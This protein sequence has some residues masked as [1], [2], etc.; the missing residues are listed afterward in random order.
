MTTASA[1]RRSER[2]WRRRRRRRTRVGTARPTFSSTTR[3][4]ILKTPENELEREKKKHLTDNL[5]IVTAFVTL[6]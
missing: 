2:R 3:A 4:L 1:S 5:V 6:D